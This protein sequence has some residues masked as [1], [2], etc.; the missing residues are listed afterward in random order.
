MASR[1]LRHD[2]TV[3]PWASAQ[4]LPDTFTVPAG[5]EVRLIPNADG[6]KG[7]LWAVADIALVKRLSGNDHDPVY[8]YV[9][10]DVNDTLEHISTRQVAARIRHGKL[11]EYSDGGAVY[12]PT[13]GALGGQTESLRFWSHGDKVGCEKCGHNVP[14]LA[15]HE[16]LG[17]VIDT[18]L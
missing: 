3:T 4:V 9:F 16:K 10:I 8:R 18:R 6:M 13:H 5:T 1:S 14:A 17:I 15:V 12:C 11:P 7:D 2:V